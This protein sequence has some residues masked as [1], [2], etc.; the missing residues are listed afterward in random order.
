MLSI[1]SPMGPRWRAEYGG[2]RLT[3]VLVDEKSSQS[4]DIAALRV[5]HCFR[6]GGWSLGSASSYIAPQPR[7]ERFGSSSPRRDLCLDDD[8]QKTPVE[9]IMQRQ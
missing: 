7:R 8:Q 4:N 1:I 2:D 5:L 9:T 3:V 6:E